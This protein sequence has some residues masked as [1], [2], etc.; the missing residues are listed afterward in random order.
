MFLHGENRAKSGI[1]GL[2]ALPE[3]PTVLAQRPGRNSY[4]QAYGQATYA[5]LKNELRDILAQQKAN[6]RGDWLES[7]TLRHEGDTL[8]VGFP[9]FYFAAWFNQQKRDL[10]EQPLTSP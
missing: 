5:M 10:F 4:P 2:W 6:D 1:Q 3:M 9:H 7:L 8:T